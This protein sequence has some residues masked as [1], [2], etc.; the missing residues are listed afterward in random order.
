MSG[1]FIRILEYEINI[2]ALQEWLSAKKYKY[3]IQTNIKKTKLSKYDK[4]IV[5]FKLIKF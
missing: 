1:M 3:I 5:K 4:I 2:D